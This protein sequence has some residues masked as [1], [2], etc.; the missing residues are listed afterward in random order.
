MKQVPGW[1]R[2]LSAC[3]LLILLVCAGMI[4]TSCGRSGSPLDPQPNLTSTG[5]VLSA[6]DSVPNPP[7][8]PPRPPAVTAQFVNADSTPAGSTGISRWL[9]GNSG[10]RSLVMN[11]TVTSDSSWS[12]FPIQGSLTVA[13]RSTASLDVPIPV[14]SGTPA[15][16]YPLLLTVQSNA[17]S[18]SAAGSI[19]V[20]GDSLSAR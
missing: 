4:A 20:P 7:G 16:S 3:F 2:S 14:P 15:G 19:T 12:A 9:L 13:R 1:S 18:A 17:G 5:A 11:W 8:P 10:P 6:P